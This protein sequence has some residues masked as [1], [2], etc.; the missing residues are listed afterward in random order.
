M[1]RRIRLRRIGGPRCVGSDG[2]YAVVSDAW[3]NDAE[4]LFE[5]ANLCQGSGE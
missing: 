2:V 3:S 4:L 1:P 5:A